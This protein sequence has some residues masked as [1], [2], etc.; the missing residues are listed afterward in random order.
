MTSAGNKN[1]GLLNLTQL[2]P[3][4]SDDMESDEITTVQSGEILA[5]LCSYD[6]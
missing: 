3:Y 4:N 1:A 5:S 6:Y 2:G